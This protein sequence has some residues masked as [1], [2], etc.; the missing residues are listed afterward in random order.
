VEKTITH[1]FGKHVR[2]LRRSQNLTQE[3]LA[4]HAKISLKYIQKI[5][6]KNPP[7]I[8]IAILEKL[9]KGLGVSMESLL[10]FK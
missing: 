1:Q 8:G 6:G 7:N 2:E 10:S 9:A 4:G 3:E 5:E